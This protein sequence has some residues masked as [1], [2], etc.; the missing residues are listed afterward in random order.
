MKKICILYSGWYRSPNGAAS[1]VKSFVDNLSYFTDKIQLRVFSKECIKEKDFTNYNSIKKRNKYKLYIE[2]FINHCSILTILY[3]HFVEERHMRQIV[4][5]FKKEGIEYDVIHCQELS[6]AYYLYK[7]KA[8]LAKKIY[9]TLHSNGEDF[10]MV[11]LNKPAFNSWLGKKYLYHK[12]NYVLKRIDKIGFVS[13][14]SMDVFSNN[15]PDFAKD[16]LFYIYNGIK[17]KDIRVNL[18]KKNNVL[19]FICVGS[20]SKRKN[21]RSLI[22]GITLLSKNQQV[23]IKLTLVGDG[24]IRQELQDYV[25]SHN[26]TNVDFVGSTTEVDSYLKNADVF[27]LASKDEGLPISIIEAMRVGLPIIGSNV[28]GIP[29]QIIDNVTGLIIGC[30]ANSVKQSY[31]K[32]LSMNDEQLRIMGN[33]SYELFRERFTLF[34]MFNNYINLYKST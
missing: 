1:F 13:K 16:Q 18:N 8:K 23:K 15:H 31:K 32:I 30:D 29:E 25:S 22:E 20:L 34:G 12:L 11:Y 14:N 9:L 17:E 27:I 2:W 28:A 5:H 4:K 24:A 19:N 26:L 7:Y 33:R 3:N 10:S 21:Q 6:T